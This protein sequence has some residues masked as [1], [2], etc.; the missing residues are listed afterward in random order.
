M[1]HF[2]NLF[3]YI[4]ARKHDKSKRKTAEPKKYY[5]CHMKTFVQIRKNYGLSEQNLQ[6]VKNC[7]AE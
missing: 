2:E 6:T 3:R 4:T 1:Y 7:N 5:R